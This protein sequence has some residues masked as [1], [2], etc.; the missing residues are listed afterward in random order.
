MG[1]RVPG[2][3]SIWEPDPSV[4]ESLRF[5]TVKYGHG[6]RKTQTGECAGEAQDQL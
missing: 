2:K 3:I 1:T 4:W 5:Q 6:S